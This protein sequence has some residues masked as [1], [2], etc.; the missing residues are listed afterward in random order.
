MRAEGGE[1]EGG[2]VLAFLCLALPAPRAQTAAELPGLAA[3]PPSCVGM[4]LGAPRAP[5]WVRSHLP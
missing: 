2:S 5:I 1:E 4:G 3:Q